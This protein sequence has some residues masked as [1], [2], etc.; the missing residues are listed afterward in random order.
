MIWL[1]ILLIFIIVILEFLDEI[2]TKFDLNKFGI[3]Q[4]S[5]KII[6]KLEEKEGEK[7]VFTYKLLSIIGFTIISW[8]IYQMDAL[9]FYILAGFIILL[10]LLVVLH[11]FKILKSKIA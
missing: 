7:G 1:Y 2:L 6:K 8:F 11:N 9:Y 10:Y 3:Q 4:E 5:N